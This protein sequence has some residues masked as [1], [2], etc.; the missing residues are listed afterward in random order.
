MHFYHNISM[1]KNEKIHKKH[2]LVIIGAGPGGYHAA[3]MAAYLGLE[4][5][6]IDPE[7]NPGGLCLYRGCIPVKSLL[8][9][10]KLKQSASDAKEIGLH[11]EEP[12]IKLEQI[13]GWKEKVVRKLTAGLGQLIKAHKINYLQGYARF[14]DS[15]TLEYE[16]MNGS[17]HEIKFR[18]AIIATGLVPVE[19]PGIETDGKYIMGSAE[20]LELNDIPGKLLIVGGG[21]IGLEMAYIYHALGSKVSITELTDGFMPRM[22]RDLVNEF[23]KSN[24]N[25]FQEIFLNTALKD[26]TNKSGIITAAFEN[27]KGKKF[28]R[29]YDRIMISVGVRPDHSRLSL[30]NTGV[31]TDTDGFIRVDRQQK[32]NDDNIMAV[33]DVTGGPLLAHKAG[34]EGRVAAEAAAGM[35]VLNDARVIPSVVYTHP[36][37]A[38]CGLSENEAK[39]KE[40]AYES[41]K[42]RWSAS[43]R[44]ITMNEKTGFTKLIINPENER[45]MGAGIVGA[46]A[47]DIISELALAIEMA[48]TAADI[49]LTIHPHPTLSE[50][51]KEAAEMYYGHPIH[52]MG[53]KT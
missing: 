32:T 33:G 53:K 8:H 38:V 40:I 25:L 52:V 3:F 35:N 24:E 18:R 39:E 31:G 13:A 28:S 30:E 34:Y 42:F 7:E 51:I 45:I 2:E 20:A 1:T 22:D 21:Y 44:A 4:V 6:L 36:E 47:G 41:V 23:N 46:N 29:E 12:G 26:A 50:T 11:F 14:L 19:L 49:S 27:D 5:T 48:A 9:L 10:A 16:D 15:A 17:K 37:I 43:G